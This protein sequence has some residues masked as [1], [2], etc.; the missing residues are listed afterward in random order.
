MKIMTPEDKK[1]GKFYRLLKKELALGDCDAVSFSLSKRILQKHF[2]DYDIEKTIEFFMSHRASCDCEVLY[3]NI[4]GLEGTYYHGVRKNKEQ[5]IDDKDDFLRRFAD[6][7]APHLK[8]FPYLVERLIPGVYNI[9]PKSA[10]I[11]IDELVSEAKAMSKKS[12]LRVCVV[13]GPKRALYIEPD[14]SVKESDSIPSGGFAAQ[15]E[16]SEKPE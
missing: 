4:P 1:W 5:R 2:H 6:P 7:Y 3:N 13:L 14:G 9:I 15:F 10:E 11:S 12:D 16:E 8:K